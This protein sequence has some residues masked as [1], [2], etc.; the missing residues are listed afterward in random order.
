MVHLYAAKCARAEL[1]KTLHGGTP[2]P[3][4]GGL[5]HC[6]LLRRSFRGGTF[7]ATFFAVASGVARS[8]RPLLR[9]GF[10]GGTFTATFGGGATARSEERG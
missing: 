7:T 8:L 2:P 1:V 4:H 6:D 10:G 5:V 9:R 3:G